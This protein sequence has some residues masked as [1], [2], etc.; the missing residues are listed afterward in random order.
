MDKEVTLTIYLV[1]VAFAVVTAL[2]G[3]VIYR[4]S[5]QMSSSGKSHMWSTE[6][7]INPLSV[8]KFLGRLIIT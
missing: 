7:M 8:C 3:S 2:G 5:A 1:V 6:I 4:V